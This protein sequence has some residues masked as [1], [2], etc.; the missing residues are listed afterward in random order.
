VISPEAPIHARIEAPEQFNRDT[1]LLVP[2]QAWWTANPLGMLGPEMGAAFVTSGGGDTLA[3]PR[4]APESRVRVS[5]A[6]VPGS[7]VPDLDGHRPRT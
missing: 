2:D 5:C 4:G 6:K 3:T 1:R 7:R